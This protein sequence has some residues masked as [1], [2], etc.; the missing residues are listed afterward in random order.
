MIHLT[1]I[2]FSYPQ[3]KM[4]LNIPEFHLER[5][6]RAVVIGPSGCGKT[7]FLHIV[8]GILK[9]IRG[10]VLIDNTELQRAGD[11][12]SRNFRISKIGFI[13]QNFELIEYL[14]VQQNILFPYSI[15]HSLKMTSQVLQELQ[16]LLQQ[17]QIASKI[18]EYP[19]HLSQGEQQRVCIAR[20]LITNA[21]LILADE[22]TGNLD[23]HSTRMAMETIEN[24]CRQR[25]TTLLM[26]THDYSLL[27]RFDHVLHAENWSTSA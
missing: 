8:A 18:H 17:M 3:T 16:T 20:A 12:F 11:A 13:F 7:T 1:D 5:G 10:K 27:S 14:N 24:I 19:H 23:P 9:P 4:L 26:V 2:E 15:N 25:G 6:K 21:P 22:P